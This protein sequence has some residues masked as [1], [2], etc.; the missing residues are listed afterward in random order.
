MNDKSPAQGYLQNLEAL[1]SSEY[2]KRIH[3][4]IN[5]MKNL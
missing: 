4:I 2:T 5:K 3:L 1:F